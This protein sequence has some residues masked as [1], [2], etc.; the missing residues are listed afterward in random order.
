MLEDDQRF[1]E[2]ESKLAALSLQVE[3]LDMALT[4]ASVPVSVCLHMDR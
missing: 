4:V 3:S 2:L 1:E